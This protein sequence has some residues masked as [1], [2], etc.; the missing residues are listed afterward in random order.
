MCFRYTGA[1]QILESF[2]LDMEFKF[3]SWHMNV[4]PSIII[5]N[6][7][8]YEYDHSFGGKSPL[9]YEKL[10]KLIYTIANNNPR[11]MAIAVDIDTSDQ[12]FWDLRLEE[13][14]ND[15]QPPVVVWE[16]DI[17]IPQK[18]DVTTI[19]SPTPC[20]KTEDAIIPMDVLGG[21]NLEL[22]KMSGIPQ[23]CDDPISKYTRFYTRCVSTTFGGVP[24]FVSKIAAA[25]GKQEINC[26]DADVP[27]R[28]YYIIYSGMYGPEGRY[29]VPARVFLENDQTKWPDLENKVVLIGGSYR[30]FDRHFT[31]LGLKAGVEIL[32]NALQGELAG[33]STPVLIGEWW[34]LL[35][36]DM[37]SGCVFLGIFVFITEGKKTGQ[38]YFIIV[39][40][41]IV[42]LLAI[43]VVPLIVPEKL[44]YI[45]GLVFASVPALL[46]VFAV[47]IV[48]YLRHIFTKMLMGKE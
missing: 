41:F 47:V 5:V 13:E 9:D 45:R 40:V 24:S 42:V 26:E 8:D 33:N 12:S 14:N 6:I 31:P 25:S 44:T 39:T 34:G 38:N 1:A 37:V 46:A 20:G 28:R 10:R 22:N 43:F 21:R 30:D 2:I 3:I 29:N 16:R 4:K 27:E 15:K 32:A 36:F 23:L 17:S 7:S 48:E 35:V 19:N 11:P 18:P